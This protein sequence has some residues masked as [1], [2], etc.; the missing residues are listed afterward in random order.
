MKPEGNTGSPAW[1]ILLFQILAVV[2]M[3][4]LMERYFWPWFTGLLP[5]AK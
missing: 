5:G 2:W 4:Y 3:G 1:G